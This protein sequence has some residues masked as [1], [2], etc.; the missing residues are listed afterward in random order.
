VGPADGRAPAEGRAVSFEV[1][2]GNF[3]SAPSSPEVALS[4]DGREVGRRRVDL[5]GRPRGAAGPETA[6]VA[7]PWSGA[8]GPHHA[9]A[10]VSV[11]G[12]RWVGDADAHRAGNDARG[13]AFEVRERLRV[14]LVDGDPA[15]P[16]GR[17]PETRLLEISLGLSRAVAP[18]DCRV[19]PS[20]DLGRETFAGTDVVVLANVDRIPDAALDRLASFVRG[21]G[22]LLHFLGDRTDPL[23]WNG[24]FRRPSAEGILPARLAPRPRLER[25]GPVSLDL[26]ASDHPALRDLTDP[27]AGTAFEPPLVSGWWPPERP[28]PA[29]VEP[30]LLL[31]DLERT[32]FL[33]ARRVGRGAVL[34]C[35]TSADFDWCGHG[36]YFAPFVQECVAWLATAGAER[37]DL[38]V[39]ETLLAEVPEGARSLTITDP[40]GQRSGKLETSLRGEEAPATPATPAAPASPA[41]AA[42]R[43]VAYPETRHVGRYVLRGKAPDAGAGRGA[44]LEEPGLSFAV[45]LDPREIDPARLAPAAL[46]ERYRKRGLG[47]SAEA[48]EKERSRE[49]EEARGDLTGVVLALGVLFVL[50]EMFL[51]SLFGSRRK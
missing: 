20:A 51:A 32:P 2:V 27:R 19:I 25:D 11:A 41:A 37:R 49:R 8:A 31:R 35:T 50:L 44:W 16:E 13:H 12:N 42:A 5:R 17:L 15:P 47:A 48:A 40:W 9:E 46:E 21:G 10:R 7:F 24:S 39:H 14:L 26:A 29:G 43:V 4:V 28:L 30:L 34:L 22:G 6:R 18:A 45:N 1:V 3:G 36:L 38:V 23:L 33:L